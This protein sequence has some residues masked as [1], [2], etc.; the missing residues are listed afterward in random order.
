MG[1]QVTF[2]EGCTM[3]SDEELTQELRE[4]DNKVQG[5]NQIENLIKWEIKEYG[6]I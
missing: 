1:I 6:I 5:I 2:P 4:D 3:N